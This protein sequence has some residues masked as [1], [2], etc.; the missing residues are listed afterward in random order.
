MMWIDKQAP[1]D[2]AMARVA[3]QKTVA[4]DI[5]ADSLYSYFDKVC[6]I[7]ISIPG[8]DLIIDP[9]RKIGL[10]AFGELLAN[11]DITKVFHGADYDL[12]ILNRDFG[13]TVSNLIDTSVAA[14]LL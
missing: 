10:S 6:L 8:E 7:Q 2:D 11:G 4:I 5:E 9:L 3:E 14:Q 12:R 13:F 1:F